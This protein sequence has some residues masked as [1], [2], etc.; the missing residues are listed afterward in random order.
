MTHIFTS[1][2]ARQPDLLDLLSPEEVDDRPHRLQALVNHGG[3]VLLLLTV[4]ALLVRPA[5]LLPALEG[6]PI[7]EFLVVACI[8]ASLQ[9]LGRLLGGGLRENPIVSF[10]ML[11][12]VAVLLSHLV[13]GNTYDARIGAFDQAKACVLLL[14]VVIQ[15]DSYERLLTMIFAVAGFV[16][17]VALLAVIQYLG[18]INLPALAAI[19]QRTVDAAGE[20]AVLVRLCGIGVFNDPNDFSLV[21]VSAMIVCCFGVGRRRENKAW[22]LLVVPLLVCGVALFLTHSRG[23]LV[24][25]IGGL[26]TFIAMRL[27]KRNALMLGCLCAPLV[28]FALLGRQTPTDSADPEDTFQTRLELWSSSFDVFRAAPIFGLGQGKLTEEIGQVTHNSFLHAYAEMGLIGGTFFFGAFY[29]LLRGLATAEPV[30]ER[31]F[32]LR[33]FMLAIVAAYAFGLLS[34]SR[35]YTVPTQ[36]IL[37]MGTASLVVLSDGGRAAL[38]RMSFPCVIRVAGAGTLFLAATYVFLRVMLQRG[39]V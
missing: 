38:P 2:R 10:A 11:L 37:G 28:L 26:A 24:G 15:V 3:F 17:F 34:L 39:P 27:G 35:V 9:R 8:V 4:G 33:P 32:Q 36:L 31:S 29:L 13:S 30:D 14:L 1:A 25:A 21:L 16:A 19:Q 5:D 12:V 20:P 22:L 7:Y 23:G 6:A 18:L